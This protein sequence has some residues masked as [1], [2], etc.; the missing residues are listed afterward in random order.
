M[1]SQT[2]SEARR[3]VADLA[4]FWETKA[5]APE[6]KRARTAVNFAMVTTKYVL[7]IGMSMYRTSPVN[8]AGSA[9]IGSTWSLE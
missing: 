8:S 3:A 1:G 9:D 6:I 2:P 7:K 5:E 4:A